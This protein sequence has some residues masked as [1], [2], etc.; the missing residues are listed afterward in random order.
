MTQRLD[1]N[2]L[3]AQHKHFANFQVGDFLYRYIGDKIVIILILSIENNQVSFRIVK[4]VTELSTDFIGQY[5][6][7]EFH[8]DFQIITP[9]FKMK[10][11]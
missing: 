3:D 5:R 11:L 2:S 10:Y 8:E 7:N 6:A 9:L 1:P 4:T